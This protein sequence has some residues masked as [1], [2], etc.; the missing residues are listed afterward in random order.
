VYA[1]LP[2]YEAK[3]EREEK[4][5]PYHPEVIEW[6]RG[7]CEELDIPWRLTAN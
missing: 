7:I 2:E 6:F 3:L 1:G 4:G 5:I